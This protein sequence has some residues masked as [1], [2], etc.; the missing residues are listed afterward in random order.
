[1]TFDNWFDNIA[2]SGDLVN[3]NGKVKPHIKDALRPG[4]K[5]EMF[6]VSEAVKAK[7]LGFKASIKKMSVDRSA[8][9]FENVPDKYGNLHSGPH[10]TGAKLPNGQSGK[11]S[12]WF[13][14]NLSNDLRN[15]NTKIEAKKII[16]SSHKKHMRLKPCK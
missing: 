15:A 3:S 2:S 1:M 7:E 11:A 4:G 8:V 14:K 6:P 16:A 5:H 13:H 10:S 9:W 12:S